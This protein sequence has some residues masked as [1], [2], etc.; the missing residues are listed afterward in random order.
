MCAISLSLRS[1][2]AVHSY[3][4]HLLY[5]MIPNQLINNINSACIYMHKPSFSLFNIDIKQIK[6]ASS[7]RN[8]Q[9]RITSCTIKSGH[10]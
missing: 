4:I 9:A 1:L 10:H 6:S 5:P 8:Y 7:K 2:H 3:Y